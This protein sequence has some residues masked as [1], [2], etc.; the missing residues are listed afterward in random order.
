MFVG[1]VG[2]MALMQKAF[3]YIHLNCSIHKYHININITHYIQ[4]TKKENTNYALHTLHYKYILIYKKTYANVNITIPYQTKHYHTYLIYSDVIS[5][6]SQ[7][8][9]LSIRSVYVMI[10]WCYWIYN[11]CVLLCKY[12]SIRSTYSMPPV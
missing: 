1:A 5:L 9:K 11:F 7:S 8:H 3:L 6:S 10:L 2:I 4:I 12:I